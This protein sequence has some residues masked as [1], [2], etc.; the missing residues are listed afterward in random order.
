MPERIVPYI[1]IDKFHM[2]FLRIIKFILPHSAAP[3]YA[4]ANLKNLLTFFAQ[5][6]IIFILTHIS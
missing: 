6:D 3:G 5:T 4:K 2:L 1:I